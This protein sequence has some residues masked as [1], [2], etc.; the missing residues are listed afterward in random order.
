MSPSAEGVGF[1]RGP[2]LLDYGCV[3]PVR[4]WAHE[5]VVPEMSSEV[6]HNLGGQAHVG[7]YIIACSRNRRCNGTST[8]QP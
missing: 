2:R 1:Y 3:P 6:S 7:G 5:L 4:V 8:M